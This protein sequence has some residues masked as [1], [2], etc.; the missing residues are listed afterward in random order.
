MK[1]PA[2]PERRNGLTAVQSTRRQPQL[3]FDPV[4][5]S[6]TSLTGKRLGEKTG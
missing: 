6:S 3:F 1:A 5:C 4:A 2:N